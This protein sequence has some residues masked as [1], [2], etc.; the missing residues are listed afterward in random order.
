MVVS[1]SIGFINPGKEIITVEVSKIKPKNAATIIPFF[2]TGW[3]LQSLV[4]SY[5]KIQSNFKPPVTLSIKS[6]GAGP[7]EMQVVVPGAS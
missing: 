7:I 3:N 4:I 5:S 6:S 1:V 2:F